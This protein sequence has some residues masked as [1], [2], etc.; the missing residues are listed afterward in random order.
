MILATEYST[1]HIF[2]VG[3]N[4]GGQRAQGSSIKE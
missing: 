2:D 3:G 4:R 1:G